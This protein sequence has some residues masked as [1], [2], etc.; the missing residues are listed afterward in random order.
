MSPYTLPDTELERML[1]EDAPQG[2]ATTFTLGI[3]ARP[4]RMVFRARGPMMVCGSEESAA[5]GRLRGL[6]VTVHVPSGRVVEAREPLLSFTGPAAAV[7]L[8]WKSAQTLME[9]LSGIASAASDIVL[10]ART[11]RPECAVVCTRKTFPG[12]KSASI[13][14]VLCGGAGAHRLNL[15]ETLLVFEEHRCLLDEPP[16]TTVARLRQ[17]WPERPVVVEVAGAEEA[18]RWI[19]AGADVIQ[20]EKWS[21]DAVAQL[22]A[23]VDQRDETSRRALL[24]AAGGVK[25]GNAADYARAGADMLVTSAPYFAPPRD[26]AV[27]ISRDTGAE[28]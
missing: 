3:G 7:H 24:A 23:R 4:A 21:V 20:L 1:L 10:A 18:M 11:G 2:D 26:V 27:T 17:R 6:A 9:Y 19:E 12:T 15:S 28:A 14:A 25:A 13:K 16:A 22:R 8:V 5:M